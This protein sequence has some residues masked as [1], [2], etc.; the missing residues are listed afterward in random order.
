MVSHRI[1]KNHYLVF[2][3]KSS[4]PQLDRR[5]ETFTN[6]KSIKNWSRD[7]IMSALTLIFCGWE[8]IVCSRG[9][10]REVNCN[11]FFSC[12]LSWANK[13]NQRVDPKTTVLILRHTKL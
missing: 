6:R 4:G 12:V 11:T 9:W 3:I 13:P 10:R 7:D 5:H 1:I 8:G 2:V